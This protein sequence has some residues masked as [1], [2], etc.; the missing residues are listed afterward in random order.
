MI[1]LQTM[2]CTFHL[3]CMCLAGESCSP[4][5]KIMPGTGSFLRDTHGSFPQFPEWILPYIPWCSP[6][7]PCCEPEHLLRLT[8]LLPLRA[9]LL[10]L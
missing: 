3:P 9:T 10:L 5:K 2:L 1:P 8:A 4:E 7:C 6:R